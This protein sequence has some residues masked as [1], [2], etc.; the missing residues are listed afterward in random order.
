GDATRD[1]ARA[2]AD[3]LALGRDETA[4][5][6]FAFLGYLEGSQQRHFDAA[7]LALDVSQA[8]LAR[9]GSPPEL[10]AFRLR[11]LASVLTNEGRHAESIDAYQRALVVQ[12]KAATGNFVE[13][14]L[15]IGLARAFVEAGRPTE[16]LDAISRG[17]ALYTQ[18]FG[19]D[20]PMIGEAQL[21]LGFILRQLNRGDE[22]VAAM[23]KALAAR[24]ASHGPE[25]PS[26]V[27]ALV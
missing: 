15:N 18:L 24:E 19:P 3:A 5:R 7:H 12:R 20:Y 23:K 10:D 26:V 17:C 27:E 1:C 16:A 8:A 2:G 11:K 21:Q 9:V 6:A 14:E 4:A 22:A 25:N 13:A